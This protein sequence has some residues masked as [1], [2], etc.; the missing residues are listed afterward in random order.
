MEG[1]GRLA[2]DV[3]ARLS[4][5]EG[6]KFGLLVGGAFLLLAM[7]L[8]WRGKTGF[9]PWLGGLG[10]L[11]AVAGLLI[12]GH[13]GPIYRAWMGLALALSKVTTPIFMGIVFYLVITP[14]GVL[15]R[16]VG[17]QPLKHAGK[18]GG[19]WVE[20]PEGVTHQSSM[21]RQF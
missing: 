4:P 2:H 3:P 11:L 14:I 1:D 9:A 7:F 17:R 5:V 18:G 6:R 8:W 12:P 13:L 10:G 16:L 15:M 20:R 19:F 21:E